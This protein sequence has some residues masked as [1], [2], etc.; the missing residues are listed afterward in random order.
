MSEIKRMDIDEN[1]ADSRL[2]EA[3]GFV[4]VGYC[5]KNEGKPIE[6]QINGA[7][8]ELERRLGMAGLTLASVV[9]MNC[10]FKNIG[11]LLYLSD[12]IKA[13]FHDNYPA[14]KAFE[15]KFIREGIAFQIDAVAFRG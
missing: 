12:I 13:R 7:F 3:G 11:D 4:F 8:D 15:T 1:W 5:M 2:V 14:R 9:Q 6:E 10:L